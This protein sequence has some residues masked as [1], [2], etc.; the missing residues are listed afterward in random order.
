[1]WL[2]L[3]DILHRIWLRVRK[4]IIMGTG[5]E[6]LC[7]HHTILYDTIRKINVRVC[8]FQKHR[9]CWVVVVH[10]FVSSTWEARAGGSQCLRPTW[11]TGRIA[12]QPGLCREMLVVFVFCFFFHFC[13]LK[14]YL[15][16]CNPRGNLSNNGVLLCL[17]SASIHCSNVEYL[18]IY[19]VILHLGHSFPSL[20]FLVPPTHTHPFCSHLLILFSVSF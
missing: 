7:G 10:A 2:Q 17:S 3:Y 19:L 9:M 8:V 12:G 4:M 13:F 20:L 5:K 1:M 11:S 18:Y 15:R 6:R 14:K 16:I